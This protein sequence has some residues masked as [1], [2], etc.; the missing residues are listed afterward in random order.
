LDL[1]VN[2]EIKKQRAAEEAAKEKAQIEAERK[3]NQISWSI[4]HNGRFGFTIRT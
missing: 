2:E 4:Y 1:T 3:K